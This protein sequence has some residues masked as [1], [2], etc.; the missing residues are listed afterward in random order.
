[1]DV[2]NGSLAHPLAHSLIHSLVPS[3]T[4]SFPHPLAR[5]L[6]PLVR[7]LHTARFALLAPLVCSSALTRSLARSLTRTW[8]SGIFLSDFPG[9]N[10]RFHILQVSISVF[11]FSHRIGYGDEDGDED[12]RSDGDRDGNED[13]AEDGNKDEDESGDGDEDG[14]S[15]GD[16]DDRNEDADEDSNKDGN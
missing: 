2:G 5:S 9:I 8:D 1:M 15:D 3:S 6:T 4:R 11:T 13:E 10:Q 7:L 14:Y 16:R 12:R